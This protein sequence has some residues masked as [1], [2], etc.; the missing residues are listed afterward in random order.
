MNL[1]LAGKLDL[2]GHPFVGAPKNL[3]GATLKN[4]LRLKFHHVQPC[5]VTRDDGA[6]LVQSDNAS[7]HTF[8]NAVVIV[9]HILNIVEELGVFERDG[10]L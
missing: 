1:L 2:F 3:R 9:L 4:I 8:Q 6:M 7:R 10:D 5:S